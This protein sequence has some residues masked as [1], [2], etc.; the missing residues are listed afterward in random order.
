MRYVLY[1]FDRWPVPP[2]TAGRKV[3]RCESAVDRHI[4]NNEAANTPRLLTPSVRAEEPRPR[5]ASSYL[6]TTPKFVTLASPVL[7]TVKFD[8][9]G[10]AVELL[11][12]AD[13]KARSNKKVQLSPARPG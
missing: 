8:D 3:Q 5:R 2:A 4:R 13:G 6:V 9:L 11:P 1:N 12:L 7:I 10:P